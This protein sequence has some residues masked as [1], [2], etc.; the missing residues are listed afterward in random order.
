[1]VLKENIVNRHIYILY[2]QGAGEYEEYW[3]YAPEIAGEDTWPIDVYRNEPRQNSRAEETKI[4]DH[5]FLI[6]LLLMLAAELIGAPILSL[7]DTATLQTLRKQPYRYGHQLAWAAVGFGLMSIITG[8]VL[9][10]TV[11]KKDEINNCPEKMAERYKP[12]FYS[13]C[14]LLLLAFFTTFKFKFKTYE[15]K[16]NASCSFFDCI[17]RF[18]NVEYFLFAFLALFTG[19]GAGLTD[20]FLFVHLI[21]L[22]ATPLILVVTTTVQS[23]S[24][25]IFFYLSPML[26]L[27]Y[28]YFRVIYAGMLTS[29][30]TFLYYSFLVSPWMVVPIE[31]LSGISY[32]CVWA[33]LVSY[34]GA[35]PKIGATL[36]GIVHSLHGGL[37][38]GIGG[39][40]GGLILVQYGFDEL[41]RSFSLI[42][43]VVVTVVFLIRYR[44]NDEVEPIWSTMWDYSPVAPYESLNEEK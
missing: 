43:V 20:S 7:A 18:N 13:C 9:H 1:M 24:K 44:R 4:R 3:P 27:K 10:Y 5:V 37:G 38:R 30:I 17:K 41:F 25:V 12:V 40:F 33:A 15:G 34:V 22:G 16:E 29:V 21:R 11:S 39:L 28:G 36:Q 14:A 23:I 26:I 2:L 42:I 19:V 31:L 35:P 32:S 6:L 8:S